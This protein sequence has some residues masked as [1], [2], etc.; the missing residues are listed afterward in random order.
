MGFELTTREIKNPLLYRLNQAPLSRYFS[1]SLASSL[2]LS[3]YEGGG[4]YK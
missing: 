4:G 2:F 3:S 1:I